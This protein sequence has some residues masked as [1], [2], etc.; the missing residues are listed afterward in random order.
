M[1]FQKVV[2]IFIMVKID[3]LENGRRGLKPQ[4]HWLNHAG[5]VGIKRSNVY[6]GSV[7]GKET[8]KTQRKTA[9]NGNPD[10]HQGA[11][12]QEGAQT[13]KDSSASQFDGIFLSI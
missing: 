1:S 6:W 5:M 2:R 8:W 12:G 11:A 7:L 4:E 3:Q 10:I 13:S 9:G